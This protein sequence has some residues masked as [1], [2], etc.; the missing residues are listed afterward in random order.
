MVGLWDLRPLPSEP[1]N[2]RKR[3]PIKLRIHGSEIIQPT[4]NVRGF[5]VLVWLERGGGGVGW[6][7]EGGGEGTDQKPFQKE[8][9]LQLGFMGSGQVVTPRG[10]VLGDGE[11]GGG[12]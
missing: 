5:C 6:V 11:A 2:W 9:A 1:V 10:G 4:F 3:M 12:G 7:G 8:F